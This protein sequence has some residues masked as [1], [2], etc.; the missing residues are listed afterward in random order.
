MSEEGKPKDMEQLRAWVETV[1]E[2]LAKRLVSRGIMEQPVRVE[3][4]WVLPGKVIIGVA[5]ERQAD[6]KRMWIIGG[7]AVLPDAVDISV[8]RNPRDVARHFCMRWQLSGARMATTAE[9]EEGAQGMIDWQAVE[10]RLEKQAEALHLLAEDDQ[11]WD[12][13]RDEPG[14]GKK[15]K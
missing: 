4:R 1:C 3:S 9:K 7:D 2:E 5:E 15:A 13:I 12:D 11:A 6:R 14:A 10:K 8:A